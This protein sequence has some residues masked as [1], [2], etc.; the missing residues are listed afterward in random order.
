VFEHLLQLIILFVVI[1]DPL[2]S[3]A[4]FYIATSNLSSKERNKIATL[5]LIVAGLLSYAVLF[6]GQGL[7][8]LFNTTIQD[9]RVASGIILGILGIKMVLGHSLTNLD[10]VKD[11]STY[12]IAAIIGTPLLTGPAAITSIIVNVNDYGILVTGLAITIVLLFI[13]LLFF[14]SSRIHRLIGTTVIQVLSTFL[15][16]ITVAWGVK[17]IREGLGF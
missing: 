3:F 1:F 4:V 5:S 7:L 6:F 2:A 16:L 8:D 12:A 10:Q 17:F 9:F 15:G 14:Q 11:N 13:G